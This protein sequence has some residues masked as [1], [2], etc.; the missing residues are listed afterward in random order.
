M[1]N[2]WLRRIFLTAVV[3]LAFKTLLFDMGFQ[4]Y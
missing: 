2:H 1:S 4:N 3:V